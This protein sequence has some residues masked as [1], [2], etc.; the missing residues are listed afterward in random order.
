M[1]FGCKLEV[2][3]VEIVNGNCFLKLWSYLQLKYMQQFWRA[4]F[5]DEKAII[6]TKSYGYYNS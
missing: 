5:K 6:F 2:K 4:S 3:C 1:I